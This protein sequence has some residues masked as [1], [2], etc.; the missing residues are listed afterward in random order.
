MAENKV[1]LTDEELFQ[2]VEFDH[3]K[4]EDTGYSKENL[5]APVTGS[6]E[7]VWQ[8]SPVLACSG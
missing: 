3:S 4:S 8:H 7:D 6:W 2:F 1:Q 5:F